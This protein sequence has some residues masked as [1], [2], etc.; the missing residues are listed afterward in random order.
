[1]LLSE[2]LSYDDIVIQC[3]DNPD[4]DAL[5]SGFAMHWYL[6]K[7]GKKPR[8]IYRGFNKVSKNNLMIMID[9]LGI[10]VSYEPNFYEK[11]ELL[12]VVDCQYGQKNVTKTKAKNISIIDHHQTT[13]ELP[14]LSEVRSNLGSCSTVIWDMISFEGLEI[15]DDI[16]LL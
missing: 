2:L 9:K 5:A 16:N 7:M 8:F 6:E 10:P 13:V 15:N 12:V 4:A 1:M 14:V 11:P 3:H